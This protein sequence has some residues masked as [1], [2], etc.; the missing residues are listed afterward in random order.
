MSGFAREIEVGM[1]VTPGRDRSEEIRQTFGLR[2]T[3]RLV[4]SYFGRYGQADMGWARLAKLAARG[5]HFVGFHPP[6]NEVGA[7][8]NL[9]VVDPAAL[10]RSRPRRVRPT[11]SWPRRVMGRFA[12]RW[13]RERP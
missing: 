8:P 6:P 10:D 9:H 13:L 3:D 1:V 2:P 12:R 11:L 5:I 4:Y 7:L